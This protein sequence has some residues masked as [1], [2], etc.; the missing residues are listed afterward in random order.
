MIKVAILCPYPFGEAPSQRFRFEQYLEF[1]KS[2]DVQCTVFPF[3]NQQGWALYYQSKKTRIKAIKVLI[4]WL[5]RWLLIPKLFT[6]DFVF[7]HREAA[8]V[9]PPI[10]EWVISKLLRKRVIYDFDDAI[11]LPNYSKQHQQIHRLKAYW[12]VKYIIRWA[13]QVVVGN[14]FLADYAKQF[15]AS[16]IIIPTTIDE[17]YHTPLTPEP[18]GNEP[19]IGWTGTHTTVDYLK[20]ITPVLERLATSFRFRVIV[21]SNE[22]P[23]FFIPNLTFVPWDKHSEIH[24]LSQF[25]IGIMPLPD[26]PWTHGKCGFKGLQYMALGI[27]T[28]ASNIGVNAEIISH[29]VNGMIVNNEDEWYQSLASLLENEALRNVLGQ[30]GKIRVHECYSVSANQ[31]KYLSLF[32]P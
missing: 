25:T 11:W 10:F 7:I 12:K 1:L 32:N 18:S 15:N 17:N 14:Q 6:M 9:G 26:E 21:I 22:E 5:K 31:N 2:N 24:D 23:T 29:G 4:G 19:V 8:P 16:V 27:P 13:H 20:I 30:K 28:V 3:L